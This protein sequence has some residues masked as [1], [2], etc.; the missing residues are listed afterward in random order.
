ML[1]KVFVG[2][3]FMLK[4]FERAN[5]ISLFDLCRDLGYLSWVTNL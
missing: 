5:G 3:L 4:I 2:V 1:G